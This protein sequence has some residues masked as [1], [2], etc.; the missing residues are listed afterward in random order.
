[1]LS[2]HKVVGERGQVRGLFLQDVAYSRRLQKVPMEADLPTDG[3]TLEATCLKLVNGVLERLVE[4]CEYQRLVARICCMHVLQ[5]LHQHLYACSQC[6]SG[7][8]NN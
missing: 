6:I 3:A 2:V 5:L 1:M 7:E 8:H 4:L